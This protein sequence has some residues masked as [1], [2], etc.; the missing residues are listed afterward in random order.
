MMSSYGLMGINLRNLFFFSV[1]Q[2][3]AQFSFLIDFNLRIGFYME[4]F[5]YTF[6]R[7]KQSL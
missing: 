1:A 3:L 2:G 7:T 6:G 5:W 4:T